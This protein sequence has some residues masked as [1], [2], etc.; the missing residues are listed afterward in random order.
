[1]FHIFNI[2]FAF[3]TLN[4]PQWMKE[5][6]DHDLSQINREAIE[7]LDHIYEKN[8]WPY[9]IE[10]FTIR[11]NKLT[12][13]RNYPWNSHVLRSNCYEKAINKIL[14]QTE[15]PNVSFYITMRDGLFLDEELPL[16][17]M[18]KGKNKGGINIPDF[19]AVSAYYQVLKNHDI[20]QYEIPWKEKKSQL[21]WRGSHIQRKGVFTRNILCN[22]SSP[23]INAKFKG[24][25]TYEKQLEYKYHIM[26]DGLASSYSHSGWK[27]FT[28]SVVFM[29]DSP[30]MQWYHPALKPYIHYIPVKE[31]LSDLIEKLQWAVEHDQES[32]IIARNARQFAQNYLTEDA[33]LIYIY[34]LFKS[35]SLF[36]ELNSNI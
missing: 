18:S 6:I 22:L 13:E 1:M 30:W 35:F 29:P 24:F 5:Q 36:L 27:F 34:F 26:I 8:L 31:D 20:T 2:I 14:S 11:D 21:M 15:L 9:L 12:I 16:F 4:C 25:I 33:N 3:S 23:L 19:E 32:E 10:K 28:N 7:K 17:L